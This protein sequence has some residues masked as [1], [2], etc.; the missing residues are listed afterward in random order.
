[1]VIGMSEV[2]KQNLLY[3]GQGQKFSF[4][5]RVGAYFYVSFMLFFEY[6][7]RKVLLN[8]IFKKTCLF[9]NILETLLKSLPFEILMNVNLLS[10]NLS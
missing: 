6:L 10:S 4:S 2:D 3:A 1:M 8:N 7:L 5:L 9:L